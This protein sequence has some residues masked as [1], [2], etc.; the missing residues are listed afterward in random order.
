MPQYHFSLEELRQKPLGQQSIELVERKGKGHP[1]SICDAVAEAVSLA[2]CREYESAFGRILHYNADKA[3]LVA[4]QTEPWPGGGKVQVP[5]RIVLGDRATAESQGK[6]IDVAGIAEASAKSWLA[7]NLRFVQP[8]RH[9]VIQNELQSGSPE[10]T[11]IFEQN[12]IAAND[13]SAAVGYAPLTET[14]QLV[15]AAERWLNSADFQQRFSAAGEDVKVMG[16]RLDRELTLTVAVAFVDRFIPDAATYFRYKE[17]MRLALAEYLNRRLHDL[18]RVSVH[19]NMLD[20]PSRGA[21]GMYLTVLG[22]SAEGA[23][24]GEVGRGNRANGLIPFNRPIS[25]EAAAGKNPI[26]HVGKIYSLLTHHIA[27]QVVSRVPGVAEIYIWLCSQIGRSIDS[28][29]IAAARLS[30]RQ[31]VQLN[32]VQRGVQ[33]II[34][35]ELSGIHHFTKRLARGEMSVW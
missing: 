35:Q 3:L 18:D 17:E 1:D 21:A 26:S 4:G 31:G 16:V 6:R 11:G 19:L 25:T 20:D 8:E 2:L 23:D 22:T 24:G 14:E 32:D 33:E 34:E 7:A 27:G 28:P 29:L 5:M 9:L 15:L 12:V 13:T 10:L 30:L